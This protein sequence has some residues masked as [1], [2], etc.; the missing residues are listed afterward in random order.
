MEIKIDMRNNAL[1]QVLG[2]AI[3]RDKQAGLNLNF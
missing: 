1:S 3:L 2:Q